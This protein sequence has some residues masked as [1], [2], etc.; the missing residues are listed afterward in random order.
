MPNP[1]QIYHEKLRRDGLASDAKFSSDSN[2]LNEINEELGSLTILFAKPEEPFFSC[3]E[4]I[5]KTEGDFSPNDSETRTF[6]HTI[7]VLEDMDKNEIVTALRRRKGAYIKN[8]GIITYGVFTAEQAFVTFSSICFAGFVKFFSDFGKTALK[9]EKFDKGF[10]RDMVKMYKEFIPNFE[11]PTFET[12]MFESREKILKA[13]CHAG[14]ETVKFRMVDSFFGNISCHHDDS[15]YISRTGSSMDS[16]ENE[17]DICPDDDSKTT[18]LTAS[19]EL[20]SHKRVYELTDAK[21]ILHGHPRF[22][23]VSSMMCD[24]ECETEM[25]CHAECPKERFIGDIPIVPGEVGNG[26]FAMVNTMPKAMTGKD[27]VIVYGHG[28]FTVSPSDFNK[29][30][31]N[32]RKIEQSCFENYLNIVKV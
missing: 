32:M 18:G 10:L 26:K 28:V 5:A 11:I 15:V 31:K 23:V 24:I 14:R 17:I 12:D 8:H 7:P 4:H 27:G 20:A 13:M 2:F 3:L 19:S 9:G 1:E 25:L 30:F 22:S 6:L 21:V 16:L 29:A